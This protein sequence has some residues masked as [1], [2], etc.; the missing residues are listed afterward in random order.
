LFFKNKKNKLKW[1]LNYENAIYD[2]LNK[3]EKSIDQIIKD[4]EYSKYISDNNKYE[5]LK[6][7]K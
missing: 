4:I 2:N 1:K 7:F 3:F 6:A 5:I